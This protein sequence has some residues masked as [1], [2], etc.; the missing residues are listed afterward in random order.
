ASIGLPALSGFV[1]EFLVLLGT[2]TGIEQWNGLEFSP[3]PRLL[4]GIAATGVILSAVYMLYLFQKVMYGPI[5]HARN[6]ELK[7]LSPREIFVFI[8]MLLMA[9]WL[10][11]MPNTFLRDIDPAVQRTVSQFNQK[12]QASPQDGESAKVV[13]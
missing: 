4:A 5:T 6:R 11:M 7:D 3:H 10:G 13:P 1:G 12:M 9:F 2:F 8:P